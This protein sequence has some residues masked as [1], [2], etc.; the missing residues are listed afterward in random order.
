MYL[1]FGKL[2]VCLA[3]NYHGLFSPA[4]SD[5]VWWGFQKQKSPFPSGK[6]A[7]ECT[8]SP[9]GRQGLSMLFFPLPKKIMKK[10]K[11]SMPPTVVSRRAEGHYFAVTPSLKL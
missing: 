10:G 4:L 11:F 1:F 2:F 8:L 7:E 5:L 3:K 9:F 6:T